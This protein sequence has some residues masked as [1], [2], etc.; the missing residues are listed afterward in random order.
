MVLDGGANLGSNG[1]RGYFDDYLK[2]E[3]R[4]AGFDPADVR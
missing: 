1:V 4:L 2:I 3:H